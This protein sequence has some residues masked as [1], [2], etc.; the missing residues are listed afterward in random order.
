MIG[1]PVR[2]DVVKV[3]NPISNIEIT[4]KSLTGLPLAINFLDIGWDFKLPKFMLAACVFF[5]ACW[6]TAALVIWGRQVRHLEYSPLQKRLYFTTI[7]AAGRP[8]T[9]SFR[10]GEVVFDDS[11]T[12]T[13]SKLWHSIYWNHDFAFFI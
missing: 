12:E 13:K 7:G 10:Q 8:V 3:P 9:N 1:R 2:A 5:F 11:V 6:Y 4:I